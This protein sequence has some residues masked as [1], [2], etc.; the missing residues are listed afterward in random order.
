[1]NI[2]YVVVGCAREYKS[3]VH[4]NFAA[5][6]MQRKTTEK[7]V[8]QTQQRQRRRHLRISIFGQFCIVL[9]RLE[10]Q[11]AN[12]QHQK[13]PRRTKRRNKIFH[14]K[15]ATRTK[16]WFEFIWFLVL[17][18]HSNALRFILWCKNLESQKKLERQVKKSK[19]NRTF[20]VWPI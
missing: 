14:C 20:C 18:R 17:M 12:E 6:Q 5:G 9:R 7:H 4:F 15:S 1:M 16:R 2:I 10:M 3:L 8:D 11:T 19:W 13:I